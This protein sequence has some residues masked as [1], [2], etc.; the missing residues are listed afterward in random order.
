MKKIL[1]LI[2]VTSFCLCLGYPQVVNIGDLDKATVLNISKELSPSYLKI[3]FSVENKFGKLQLDE[4]ESDFGIYA[5]G[6]KI[7]EAV[8]YDKELKEGFSTLTA[9]LSLNSTNL[10]EFWKAHISGEEHSEL[11]ERA[12]FVYR[13]DGSFLRLFHYKSGNLTTNLLPKLDRNL[14][15]LSL[16]LSSRW[17]NVSDNETEIFYWLNVGSESEKTIFLN[18]S[19]YLND[20]LLSVSE[21]E[22][23]L[24]SG[25]NEILFSQTLPTL[26]LSELLKFKNVFI[27]RIELKTP[28]KCLESFQQSANF[29]LVI[30]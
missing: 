4:N 28:E 7:G 21:N 8:Y 14:C 11:M 25:S 26:E 13:L 9:N 17:G 3:I 19:I 20:V 29:D 10:R 6:I 1:T 27:W 5:N 12:Y 16:N 22:I 15:N 23:N 30:E 24:T 2:I 18:I